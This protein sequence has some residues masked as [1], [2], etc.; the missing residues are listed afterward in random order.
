MLSLVIVLVLALLALVGWYR[1]WQ[2]SRRTTPKP[3]VSRGD[4]SIDSAQKAAGDQM[5]ASIQRAAELFQKNLTVQ[6]LKINDE[7]EGLAGRRLRQQV[8]VTATWAGRASA[9]PAAVTTTARAFPG[10]RTA[11]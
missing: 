11:S 4:T 7:L 2:L 6:A 1:A 10:R 5:T 9:T 8:E 3:A